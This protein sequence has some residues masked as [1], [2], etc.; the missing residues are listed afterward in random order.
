[1]SRDTTTSFLPPTFT[2]AGSSGAR[3]LS[4]RFNSM[5]THTTL[6]R[7]ERYAIAPCNAG[8]FHVMRRQIHIVL[9]LF[10]SGC[11]NTRAMCGLPTESDWQPIKPPVSASELAR[12]LPLPNPDPEILDLERMYRDL[13]HQWY[14]RADGDLL[15]CRYTPYPSHPRCNGDGWRFT[16]NSGR[17]SATQE[18]ASWCLE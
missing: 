11:A 16:R 2:V 5:Q 12:L 18:W 17:W 15:L 6:R 8:D 14:V 1:M 4:T 10:L 3:S 13:P 9:V 7:T